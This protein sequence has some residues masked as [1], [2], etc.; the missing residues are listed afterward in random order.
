MCHSVICH[1]RTSRGVRS[2]VAQ[3]TVD[4]STV[5]VGRR[6]GGLLAGIGGIDALARAASRRTTPTGTRR[7]NV[8]R[9]IRWPWP[10]RYH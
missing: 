10:Y 9:V 8:P 5:T 6:R 2:V 3:V 1:L 4:P 7:M